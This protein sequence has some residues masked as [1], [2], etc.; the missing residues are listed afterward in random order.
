MGNGKSITETE[1]KENSSIANLPYD[2][3]EFPRETSRHYISASSEDIKSMLST[4]GL[5]DM[6]QL[7]SHIQ[8]NL[9]FPQPLE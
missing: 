4:I 5:G 1:L 2:P 3:S 8:P 9:L 7:F 6:S